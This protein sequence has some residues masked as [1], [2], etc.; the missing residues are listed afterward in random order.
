MRL[1]RAVLQVIGLLAVIG[2]ILAASALAVKAPVLM[3]RV[4][5]ASQADVV[6][7]LRWSGLD[8]AQPFTILSSYQ[9]AFDADGDYLD[10]ICVQLEGFAPADGWAAGP[11]TDATLAQARQAAL[12]RAEAEA[13]FGALLDGDGP[14]LFAFILQTEVF[15]RNVDG[16]RIAFYHGAT[17]RLLYVGFHD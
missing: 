11:E 8:P 3:E 7:V 15:R 14:G 1:V 10:R 17:R 6:E 2:A 4:D 12:S 16:A 9:S 5:K 13:C